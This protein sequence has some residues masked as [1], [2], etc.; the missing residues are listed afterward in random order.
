MIVK[1]VDKISAVKLNPYP[2]TEV[3]TQLNEREAE[4]TYELFDYLIETDQRDF[5]DQALDNLVRRRIFV[6]LSQIGASELR[7]QAIKFT[8]YQARQS[9]KSNRFASMFTTNEELRHDIITN[10]LDQRSKI[11][12]LSELIDLIEFFKTVEVG[13]ASTPEGYNS[14]IENL[15]Q[16]EINV[17]AIDADSETRSSFVHKLAELASYVTVGHIGRGDLVAA[18]SLMRSVNSV[19][20]QRDTS[21]MQT[22]AVSDYYLNLTYELMNS[23]IEGRLPKGQHSEIYTQVISQMDQRFIIP[24]SI[25]YLWCSPDTLVPHERKLALLAGFLRQAITKWSGSDT[26]LLIHEPIYYSIFKSS[27]T[28]ADVKSALYAR[29]K[30]LADQQDLHDYDKKRL[31]EVIGSIEK[32]YTPSV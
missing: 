20:A 10:M 27:N 17:L 1:V 6:D 2:Q 24:R 29:I 22:R 25:S 18:S 5:S 26:L 14:A 3:E 19:I 15:L 23:A 32:V 30:E 13:R 11:N 8:S 21:G 12:T 7:S 16:Q 9:S 28:P 31:S 4:D